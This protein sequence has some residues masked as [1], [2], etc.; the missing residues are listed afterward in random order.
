MGFWI[1]GE[2]LGRKT[3]KS[4][5]LNQLLQD[6]I[7][8]MM[9]LWLLLIVCDERFVR[10]MVQ[11]FLVNNAFRFKRDESQKKRGGVLLSCYTL[12]IH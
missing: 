11:A 4:K 1:R 9:K 3:K 12:E 6:T 5:I 8:H 7:R 10:C 2:L